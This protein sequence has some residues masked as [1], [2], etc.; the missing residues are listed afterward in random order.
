MKPIFLF[1]FGAALGGFGTY[2]FSLR[3]HKSYPPELINSMEAAHEVFGDAI[4]DKEEWRKV[5]GSVQ[6]ADESYKNLSKTISVHRAV[7]ALGIIYELNK[8]HTDKALKGAKGYVKDFMAEYERNAD[9]KDH[10]DL[11]D[12]LHARILRSEWYHA[13]QAAASDGD[14]P[15][16]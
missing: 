10:Q 16:N 1:L 3:A 12:S 5:W 2:C 4:F 7:V 15:P 8:G 9:F 13:E 11:A 6:K 14:K